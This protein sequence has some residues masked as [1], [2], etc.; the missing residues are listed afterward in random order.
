MKGT[1]SFASITSHAQRLSKEGYA[2]V[3]RY[4]RRHPPGKSNP[5]TLAEI[6]ELRAAGLHFMPVFEWSDKITHFTPGAGD[7]D[8]DAALKTAQ[9][10]SQPT[11][12]AIYFAVDCNPDG[13]QIKTLINPYF[14]RVKA[15]V[16][17]AGY[18]VGVYS[19]GLGCSSLLDQGLA[20]KAWL[21]NAKAWHG[22]TA[23]LQSGRWHVLQS[24][25][26]K[27]AWPGSPLQIDE[28]ECPDL[29]RA[30]LWNLGA[31]APGA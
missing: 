28:N 27:P 30:A 15:K 5:V 11:G 19:S 21:A 3:A 29:A 23:F 18:V 4:Y 12:T 13:N 2:F 24:S 20:E 1:D 25:L 6:Q 8:A 9:A 10:L 16:S 14:S 22:Y 7:L 17:A 26:P 31:V